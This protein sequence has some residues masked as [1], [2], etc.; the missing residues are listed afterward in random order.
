MSEPLPSGEPPALELPSSEPLPH[1]G[2][3]VRAGAF[4]IDTIIVV[5]VQVALTISSGGAVPDA[6]CWLLGASY[7]VVTVG[8]WGQ[9]FGH[10]AAGIKVVRDAD[11]GPL[12][13]PGALIRYLVSILSTVAL[14]LGFLIVPF[15][16]RKRALHDLAA[17]S[18]VVYPE[19]VG[20]GRRALM[21]ALGAGLLLVPFAVGVFLAASPTGRR[22]LGGAAGGDKFGQLMRKSEEGATKGNLGSLRAAFSIYYGDHEGVYPKRVED[23]FS[24]PKALVKEARP[25]QTGHHPESAAFTAYGA[26]V[27]K[28]GALDASKL[29]DTGGWG[30]VS[31]P[32]GKCDGMVFVNCTHADTKG[33]PWY[34]Y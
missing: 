34:S 21:A 11:D 15:T 33:V 26:E 13:Y 32:E 30:Y 17:G 12:G 25:A 22:L 10:M 4:T 14:F 16:R 31:M 1:A 2:F 5:V 18:V 24:D 28:D 19:P 6:A 27:C 29:S 23:L 7:A 3:W 9:S 20:A 8:A